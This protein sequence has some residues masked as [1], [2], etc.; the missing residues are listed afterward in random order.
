[1]QF[2]YRFF[3][4]ASA[5]TGEYGQALATQRFLVVSEIGVRLLNG[6]VQLTFTDNGKLFDPLKAAGTDVEAD[7]RERPEGGMGIML[8][9]TVSDRISYRVFEGK[10]RLVII[11]SLVV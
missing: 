4:A 3:C 8:V 9:K 10:N 6:V 2:A 7:I 1:M 11:K 5:V